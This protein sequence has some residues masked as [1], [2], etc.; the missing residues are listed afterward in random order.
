MQRRFGYRL[1][2]LHLEICE[3][4]VWVVS[5]FQNGFLSALPTAIT[6]LIS[7]PVG[8]SADLLMRSGRLNTGTLRKLYT[9]IAMYFGAV[10]LVL[11]AFSE[12]NKAMAVAALC[13]ANGFRSFV[14]PGY[15]VSN[16]VVKGHVYL[17]LI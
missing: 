16:L 7:F 1:T 9:S 6:Y 5:V 13:I 14:F 2:L 4:L 3:L 15:I 17:G 10:G 11:V 8:Y 12:C